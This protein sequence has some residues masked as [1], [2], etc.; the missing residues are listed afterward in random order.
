MAKMKTVEINGIVY[1]A[2]KTTAHA[3]AAPRAQKRG[4][5]ITRTAAPVA[6]V[7]KPKTVQDAPDKRTTWV[8]L[9][10]TESRR[11]ISNNG[12]TRLTW[13]L[14]VRDS[15]QQ[16]WTLCVP[17]DLLDALYSGTVKSEGEHEPEA[18]ANPVPEPAAQ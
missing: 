3:T 1:K 17:T 5:F 2:M 9:L 10:P 8:Q 18:V 6:Q 16:E 12:K 4:S 14:G 7:V 11:S 13:F 15:D